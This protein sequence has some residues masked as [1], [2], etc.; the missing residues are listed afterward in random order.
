MSA[1]GFKVDPHSKKGGKNK[2]SNVQF[3]LAILYLLLLCPHNNSQ[4]HF[5]IICRSVRRL[6][7]GFSLFSVIL[8]KTEHPHTKNIRKSDPVARFQE[9]RKSW[10]QQKAPGE[11]NHKN[12]RWNVRE[13]MLAQDVVYEKVYKLFLVKCFVRKNGLLLLGHKSWNT[14]MNY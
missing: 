7:N 8:R 1:V 9:F 2:N 3:S 14:W 4:G 11:K 12:L 13:Q 10:D 5:I 6:N